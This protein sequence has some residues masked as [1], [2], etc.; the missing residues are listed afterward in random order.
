LSAII[1][2]I[3]NYIL[4]NGGP[5]SAWYCGVAADPR[6]RVLVDHNVNETSGRWTA[7]D[8]GTDTAARAVE[9]YFLSKGC[10]GG[11]G[12]GDRDTRYVY[13]YRITP[14]TIQ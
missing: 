1:N 2:G 12:G 13:A 8:C 9:L 6:R 11:P 3:E 7:S 5:F 14:T 4:G 10:K